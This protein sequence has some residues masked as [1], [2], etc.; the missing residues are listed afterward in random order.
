MPETIRIQH[1]DRGVATL[2]LARPEKHNALSRQMLD[3]LTEA[4]TALAADDSVRVVVLAAEGPSFCAGGD[5]AWMRQ[6]IDTDAATR[7]A[8]AHAL[9]GMLSALNLLPKPL[10]AR[11]HGNAFGGGVG[12][13][14]VSDVALVADQ[15]RFGLTEV[16][17]GLIPATIGP[18][19]MARMGEDRARRVYFSGRLFDAAEARD[20]NLATRVLPAGDLDAAVEAEIAPYLLAAP[21]AIAA[22]KAQCRA[23]G[24][25]IDAQVIEDSIDRL[26]ATWEG[27]EA[28]EGI[29]AFFDKRA[30]SWQS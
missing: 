12:M 10:I 7:R 4:A 22:A 26:V 3:E 30:P 29:T 16:K 11:V 18:Y 6:Q 13:M 8:G 17:L 25:R 23:L 19:V 5:L 24:P 15:A 9:A 2:W 28:V 1:D 27:P 20:L 14:A 21:R